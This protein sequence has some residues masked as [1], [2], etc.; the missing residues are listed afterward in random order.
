MSSKALKLLEKMRN[1]SASWK[2]ED[3]VT[4]YKGFGFQV[5]SGGKHDKITHPDFPQLITFLP[6]HTKLARIYV[7]KAVDLVEKLIQL[8]E[9]EDTQSHGKH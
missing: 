4:L 5:I 3:I 2:R 7:I 1:T 6:R 9:I 8:R